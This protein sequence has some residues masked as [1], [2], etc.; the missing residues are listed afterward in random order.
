MPSQKRLVH[1]EAERRAWRRR[2]VAVR[3]G[4]RVEYLVD[5]LPAETRSALCGSP[6]K[7]RAALREL[8]AARGRQSSLASL[9]GASPESQRRVDARLAVVNAFRRFHR[10]SGLS[11]VAAQYAFCEGYARGELE[12]EPWVREEVSRVSPRSLQRWERQLSDEGVSSLAGRYGNRRG[13]GK[14]DTQPE[15]RRFV[16]AM[17]TQ[18]PHATAK[19]VHRAARARFASVAGIELPSVRALERWMRR[20]REEHVELSLAVSNP[21]A[22]KSR[23]MVAY[24]SASEDVSRLNQRWEMDSTPADVMLSDG[25]H[26]IIGVVDVYSRRAKLL[27]SKTSRATA[28]AALI[29]RALLDWGVPES[30]KTD[31]GADYTSRHIGRVVTALEIDHLLCEKFAPWL[32]PHVERFFRTF[33]HDLVE[34]LPGYIGHDV[35]ERQAIEAR[36]S[37]ADRLMSRGDVIDVRMSANEFQAICDRWCE[38]VYHHETHRGL[39]KSP[40]EAAAAWRGRVRRVEDERALDV[41][42]AEAPGDGARTVRKT[43]IHID[44]LTYMAPELSDLAGQRVR[45]LYDPHDLGRVYVFGAEGFVCVAECP[46]VTGISRREVAAHARE[47]QRQRVQEARRALK[48][49]ARHERVKDVAEEMLAASERR[50]QNLVSFPQPAERHDTDELAAAA[51]AVQARDAMDEPPAPAAVDAEAQERVVQMMREDERP[52]ESDDERFRRA[53]ALEARPPG[54]LTESERRWLDSYRQTGEYLGLRLTYDEL[55]AWWPE[56]K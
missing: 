52:K 19:H 42:L 44:G 55:G 11:K 23:Y 54:L 9:T 2:T 20:W 33:A 15:L 53:L 6:A 25:R 3:G 13:S 51:Q 41:L 32:K 30:I 47:R 17:L 31:Q 1:L 21:D 5:A 8:D 29:R 26:S 38:A 12:V 16:E 22:W 18:H 50:A 43:G 24:G 49:A 36:R 7:A 14:V 48:A 34:L 27:V 4:Q 37:F 10:E 46:E 56:A 39:G 45:V 40:F 35:A 28:I